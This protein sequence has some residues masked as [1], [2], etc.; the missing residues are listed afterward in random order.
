MPSV[1]RFGGLRVVVYPNDHRPAHVHVMGRGLEAIFNLNCASGPVELR[2]NFGFSRRE[3][4]HIQQ[5]L[6]SNVGDL[7]EA[8]ERIHG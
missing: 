1:L 2:V 7:C 5:E 4:G 3:L 8:W 6:N